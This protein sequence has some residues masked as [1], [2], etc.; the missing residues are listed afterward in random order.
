MALATWPPGRTSELRNS[1]LELR[2]GKWGRRIIVSVALSP[3][4]AMSTMGSGPVTGTLYEKTAREQAKRIGWRL[5]FYAD[6]FSGL[7][8]P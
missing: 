7:S 3:T 5:Y 8:Q 4:P 1:T 2:E 6:C